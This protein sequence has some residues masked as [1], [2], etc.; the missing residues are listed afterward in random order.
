[1][2]PPEAGCSDRT[3]VTTLGQVN[4]AF[5]LLFLLEF[6]LSLQYDR[7]TCD[8]ELDVIGLYAWQFRPDDLI[9]LGLRKLNY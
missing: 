6:A 5:T 1:L 8:L 2:L 9:A 4:A 3:P 7:F